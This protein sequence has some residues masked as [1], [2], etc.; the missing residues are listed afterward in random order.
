MGA[1]YSDTS[2]EMEDLQARLLRELPPERK[3]VLMNQLIM[4]ARQL[5]WQGLQQRYPEADEA[6]LRQRFAEM[7]LGENEAARSFGKDNDVP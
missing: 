4:A 1:F 6:E 5:A 3:L 2:I 7:V